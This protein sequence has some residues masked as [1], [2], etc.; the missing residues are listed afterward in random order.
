MAPSISRALSFALILG[1]IVFPFFPARSER[2]PQVQGEID[3]VGG[4]IQGTGQGTAQPSGNKV[5]DRI[6][7]IRAAEVMAQRSLAETIHG[8]RIDGVTRMRDAMEEYVVSSRV[9]G[10][11]R[12]AQKIKTELTWDG[13]APIATVVLRICLVADA[14][15]CRSGDSLIDA[16]PVRDRKEP[17]YVPAVYYEAVPDA[18]ERD[19][20]SDETPAPETVSYDSSR[21][22]TGLVLQIANG[23]YE[24]EL[25]PVVVTPGEKESFQTVFSAK[26]VRPEIIRTY[27]VARYADSVDQALADPRLGDNP[28]IVKVFGVTRDNMLVVPA[29]GARAIRETT[30]YGNDYLREAKV[31]IAGR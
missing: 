1:I 8:V 20:G 28:V 30:R 23:R 15:Q 16:L 10:I 17:S 26:K 25:F 19:P 31:I 3:W 4:Y 18:G 5:K 7:A 11:I 9:E 14:P 27:G 6:L 2:A 21:P 13:E 29:E 22:V 24:R 12:G